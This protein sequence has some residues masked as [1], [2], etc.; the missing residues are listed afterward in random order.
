MN[1][2]KNIKRLAEKSKK[3]VQDCFDKTPFPIDI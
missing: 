1:P 3:S 2:S